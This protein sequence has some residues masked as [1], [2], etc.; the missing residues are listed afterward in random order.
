MSSFIVTDNSANEMSNA[1]IDS[2]KQRSA[3]EGL[4]LQGEGA[5]NFTM[6]PSST[7]NACRFLRIDGCVFVNYLCK[8]NSYFLY[9]YPQLAL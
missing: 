9:V 5:D 7:A 4:T 2:G 6:H 1:S 3:T 8:T